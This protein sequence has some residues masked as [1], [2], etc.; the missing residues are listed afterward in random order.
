MSSGNSPEVA[1][2]RNDFNAKGARMLC[3]AT[4]AVRK[5]MVGTASGGFVTRRQCF[6]VVPPRSVAGRDDFNGTGGDVLVGHIN[7]QLSDWLAP[8]PRVRH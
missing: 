1:D 7:G 8:H 2:V 3:G 5:Q 6:S 4:M